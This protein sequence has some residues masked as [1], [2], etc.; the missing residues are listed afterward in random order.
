MSPDEE[1]GVCGE[2]RENHGDKMHEFT[3]TDQ[4]IQKK[5]GEP[6]RQ[7]PPR[8]RGTTEPSPQAKA[9][10]FACLVEVLAEKGILD[11]HDIIRIFSAGH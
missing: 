3:L 10:S 1:C 6:A 7:N 2:T 9:A 11:H 4:V 5:P 8:E